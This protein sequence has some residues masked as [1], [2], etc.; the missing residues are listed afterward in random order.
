MNV[1]YID[2]YKDNAEG[3]A[4]NVE[5]FNRMM[6]IIFKNFYE[7]NREFIENNLKESYY[8]WQD[9]DNGY[10]CEEYILKSMPENYKNKVMCV[11]YEDDKDEE[12]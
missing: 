8:D 7:F 4:F 3:V 5:C 10:C 9:D 2:V 1:K 12:E 6:I 11:I